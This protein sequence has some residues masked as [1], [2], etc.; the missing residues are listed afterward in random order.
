[1]SQRPLCNES[2][3]ICL[4]SRRCD[5]FR[6]L[7]D[8]YQG[9][10][11]CHQRPRRFHHAHHHRG[12]CGTAS[13]IRTAHPTAGVDITKIFTADFRFLRFYCFPV[14]V[15]PR[16]QPDHR[17]SRD[18]DPRHIAGVDRCDCTV[19]GSASAKGNLVAGMRHRF[20]RRNTPALRPRGR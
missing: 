4:G 19:L 15:H 20:R 10:S 12:R 14:V 9:R 13:G 2:T 6:R 3:G 8:R 16:R 11:I 5:H 18:H 7:G 1:M 17:Q